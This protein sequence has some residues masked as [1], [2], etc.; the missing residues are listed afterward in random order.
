M[1]NK[2]RMNAI[3]SMALAVMGSLSVASVQAQNADEVV[4]NYLNGTGGKDKWSSVKTIR[5]RGKIKAQSTE[6]P[7]TILQG[8]GGKMK[9][10]TLSHGKDFVQMAFDGTTAWSTNQATLLPEKMTDEDTYN[11]KQD[12]GS[13]F[14]DPFLN[15]KNKG[16]KVE[17]Q[18]NEKVENVDCVKVKMTKNPQKVNNKAEENTIDYFLDAQTSVPLMSRV[19]L[20]QGPVRGVVQETY[21]SNYQKVQGIMFPFE[22]RYRINGLQGQTIYI[23]SVE[24]NVPLDDKEFALPTNN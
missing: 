12:A 16:Y 10:S 24:L 15:Y 4:N 11:L 7:V 18:G 17:I 21:F 20:K 22:M 1:K 8:E 5:M 13:D 9:V 19:K 6:L 3:R 14:P 23:E 2:K